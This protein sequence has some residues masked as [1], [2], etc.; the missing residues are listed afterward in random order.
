MSTERNCLA[1]LESSGLTR[2]AL[3][4]RFGC[5][6]AT[7]YRIRKGLSR[8]RPQLAERIRQLYVERKRFMAEFER[9]VEED[10]KY[11]AARE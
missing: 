2:R 1:Y 4:E 3:A 7:L 11:G 8:P 5:D 6:A 10:Q 9:M